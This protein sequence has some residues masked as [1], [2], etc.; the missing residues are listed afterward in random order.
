MES[1][2]GLFGFLQGTTGSET[3]IRLRSQIGGHR[4]R[5]KAVVLRYGTTWA[6]VTKSLSCIYRFLAVCCRVRMRSVP[7]PIAYAR[8]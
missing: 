4:S 7:I 1:A 3:L 2:G 6:N 5:A 8:L